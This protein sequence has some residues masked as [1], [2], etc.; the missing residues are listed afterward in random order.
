MA[1]NVYHLSVEGMDRDEIDY[2]VG[3]LQAFGEFYG[4]VTI[5]DVESEFGEEIINIRKD[6]DRDEI[7]KD[8]SDSMLVRYDEATEEVIIS[9]VGED[10]RD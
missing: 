4:Q 2:H 3:N 8:Y 7:I 5:D 10:E 6:A 9:V 1:S